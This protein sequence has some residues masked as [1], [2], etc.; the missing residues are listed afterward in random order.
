MVFVLGVVLGLAVSPWFFLLCAI[1]I[2]V[3]WLWVALE[4]DKPWYMRGRK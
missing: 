1:P 4:L 3:T 2:V